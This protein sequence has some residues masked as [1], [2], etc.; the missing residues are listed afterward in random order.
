MADTK[1]L[2]RPIYGA[3]A[4]GDEVGLQERQAYYRL[5]KGD[6]PAEKLGNTWVSTPRRLRGRLNTA[7]A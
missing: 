5:E 1:E 2:D 7:A 6:L 4:I 3:K